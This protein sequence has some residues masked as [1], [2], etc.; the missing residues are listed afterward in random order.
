ML[1]LGWIL[2]E[3]PPNA[4]LAPETRKLMILTRSG[5]AHCGPPR[6]HRSR[7]NRSD[8]QAWPH[9]PQGSPAAAGL[10]QPKAAGGSRR[11]G[12]C[13]SSRRLSRRDI[14]RPSQALQRCVAPLSAASVS[15]QVPSPSLFSGIRAVRQDF[16]P[17]MTDAPV[18]SAAWVRCEFLSRSRTSTLLAAIQ[19][20]RYASSHP[21]C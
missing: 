17:G 16:F 4:T 10:W 2:P 18:L 3:N 7:P 13:N 15:D 6:P 12:L 8:R 1:P 9:H 19:M 5:H 21:S 20:Q 14:E 11:S